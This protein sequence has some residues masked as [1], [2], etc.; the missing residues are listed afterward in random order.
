[1]SFQLAKVHG[2]PVRLHFTLVIVFFL[3]AWTL[4]SSFMPQYFPNLTTAQYWIMGA[5]GA[6]ILFVSVFLHELM[7]SV[8]AMRYGMKVRQIVLFIFGGV[9]DISEDTKDFRKEF[10]IAIAGPAASFAIAAVLAAL[11]WSLSW[12]IEDDGVAA[13]GMQAAG[14]VVQGVLLYGAITNAL[15][16]A[17]NLIPAF[18]LDGGRILRAGL[19]RWK[20]SYDEATKIAARVGIA[21]SYGFMGIG[22]LAMITGAFISGVWILLIGWFLNSGAQSYL[23][24][25]ELTTMLAGVRLRD[26]MN[27]RIIAVP[28]D[29]TVDELLKNYFSAYMKSS[30]PVVDCD[31]GRRRLA[32]MVTLKMALDI[33]DNRRQR[34]RTEEVMIPAGDLVVMQPD[35]KADEALMEMTRTHTGKVFVC[36]VEGTLLG[37]VSKT[38][39]MNVAS[40]RQDYQKEIQGRGD[41]AEEE[42]ERRRRRKPAAATDSTT[43]AA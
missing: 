20:K 38:D 17:F 27:T 7:H 39:I 25:H 14:Q 15:L 6:V 21:I 28:R 19:V 42:E 35:R 16:G 32:G 4:A 36:D 8:V 23:A 33:P 10:N 29:T 5:A 43:E 1:M 26:I 22:F 12:I 18:P 2:I 40:E 34:T 41:A 24:Q 37:L 9:S 3:I 30:F 11:W 13:G 31:D